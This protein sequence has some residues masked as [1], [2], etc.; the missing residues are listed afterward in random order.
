M[1]TVL[2]AALTVGVAA[3]A[4]CNT[5]PATPEEASLI[6]SQCQ[7]FGFKPGTDAFA[8][9]VLQMDQARVAD[10]RDRRQRVGAALAQ[11]GQAQQRTYR[12]PVTCTAMRT[13]WMTTAQ[14]Y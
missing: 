11:V 2:I 8:N 4:G 6:Q 12:Q 3:L 5:G 14:C 9:C 13:G 1:R 7:S 10:A